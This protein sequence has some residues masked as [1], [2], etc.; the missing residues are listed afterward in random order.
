M[1][2]SEF[3]KI[4]NDIFDYIKGIRDSKAHDYAKDIDT[5][6]NFKVVSEICSIL[7]IDVRKSGSEVCLFFE[8]VKLARQCNLRGKDPKAESVVDTCGDLINYTCLW[9]GCREDEKDWDARSAEQ[10]RLGLPDGVTYATMRLNPNIGYNKGIIGPIIPGK[11]FSVPTSEPL[12]A[13]PMPHSE[14]T[15]YTSSI[16]KEN[17]EVKDFDY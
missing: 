8:I 16:K 13:I 5:L 14:H 10:K 6:S 17:A 11:V 12:G 15:E 2:S 9:E 4:Q 7:D 3:N 1:L